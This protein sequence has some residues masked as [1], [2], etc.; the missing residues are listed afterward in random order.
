M[1]TAIRIYSPLRDMSS[2]AFKTIYQSGR[3]GTVNCLVMYILVIPVPLLGRLADS[4][5]SG[6][7]VILLS[8]HMKAESR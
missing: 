5:R 2:P 3:I 6:L 1:L 7:G 4:F 8:Q